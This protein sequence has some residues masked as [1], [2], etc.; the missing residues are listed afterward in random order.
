MIQR[1]TY[2]TNR[3]QD[4]LGQSDPE[5]RTLGKRQWLWRPQTEAH[6]PSSPLP[7]QRGMLLESLLVQADW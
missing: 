2:E 4:P 7:S 6:L 1:G 3:T 5:C